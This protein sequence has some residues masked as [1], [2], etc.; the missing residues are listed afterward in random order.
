M[1]TP[2]ISI[3][4]KYRAT[5]LKGKSKVMTSEMLS[6]EIGVY[7]EVI[8]EVLSFFN[9]LVNMD[10]E[11]NLKDLLGEIDSYI[12]EN[13]N[14]K[15]KVARA[16]LLTKKIIGQ[17]GGINDFIY[18][19]MTISGFFERKMILNDEELKVLKKLITIE[20]KNR[21]NKK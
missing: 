3:L 21:K 4:K 10:F 12:D 16:N 14:K 18:E 8:R 17:Y 20:Q 15:P 1:K 7:P 13:M 9:P 5:L 19:K 2:P 11:F 6:Q